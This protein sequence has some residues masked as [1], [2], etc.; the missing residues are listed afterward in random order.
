MSLFI[1]ARAVGGDLTLDF[2]DRAAKTRVGD[3][4]VTWGLGGV[5]PKGIVVGDVTAVRE[6][7]DKPYARIDVTSRV[8]ISEIEEAS[9]CRL[10]LRPCGQGAEGG[11]SINRVV[12]ESHPH[13]GLCSFARAVP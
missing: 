8:P 7:R 3:V 9:G 5:Y 2:V 6:Q 12:L 13:P 10:D 11:R 1:P 4:L